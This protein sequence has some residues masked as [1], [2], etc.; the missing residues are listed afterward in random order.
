[1]WLSLFRSSPPEVFCKKGVLR[2]FTKFKG[3]DLC[4]SFF[5]NKVTGPATLLKKR[6]LQRCFPANFEKFPKNTFFHRTPLLAVSVFLPKWQTSSFFKRPQAEVPFLYPRKLLVFCF[7]EV[8]KW[9]IGLI[10]VGLK[11]APIKKF[12]PRFF[13][14]T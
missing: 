11:M 9:N 7:Q 1:M 12:D 4:Q 10:W 6:L 14:K 8:H 5:N 3:K 2:N 13:H